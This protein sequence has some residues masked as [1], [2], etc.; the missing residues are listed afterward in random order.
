MTGRMISRGLDES[1]AISGDEAISCGTFLSDIE[2]WADRLPESAHVINLCVDR[3]LFMVAF[4]AAI[5]RGQ[6]NLL[7]T[8]HQSE[9]V[10][11]AL[12][13]YPDAY[14]LSD[15]D[16]SDSEV[17][18]IKITRD[19]EP[20]DVAG[21]NPEIPD[22]QLAAVVFTSGSTGTSKPIPKT[23]GTL[24]SGAL[25]N[26]G[27]LLADG[28]ARCNLIATVPPWH[29]YGLEWSIMLCL[30]SNTTTYSGGTF[31]PDDI[32]LALERTSG[33]RILIS[34]PLHLRAM[35]NSGV[36]F[37]A[38]ET[39]LCA[40]APLDVDFAQDV[41]RNF[42]ASVFEI[43]GCSEAGSMA[44]RWPTRDEYWRFLSEFHVE[45]GNAKVQ[46]SADHVPD[47][48]ELADT[49][50]FR[51]DGSFL[52]EGRNED[53]VKVAG[54]RASLGELNSRLLA[55]EGIED[56]VI[57]DPKA[58]GVDSVRLSALVVSPSRNISD[59]RQ[60]LAR[61]VDPVFLPRPI[62]MVDRLPRSETG[63]LRR[64]ELSRMIKMAAEKS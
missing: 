22:T 56:G 3:Y 4:F 55:I 45:R 21:D 59:I 19:P 5:R 29:M 52:L 13:S 47:V 43:Y 40:T 16:F 18:A 62:K 12:Q 46:I 6:C 33:K 35:L 36:D 48:I 2:V 25:M 30:V 41:E 32:R 39:V 23:W 57:Y 58:F 54:K 1:V 20:S 37:P 15:H 51:A 50:S 7:L 60:D 31:F 44:C 42:S 9:I 10:R 8:G 17:Q 63:K 26:A 53:M 28:K 64:R 34:T 38:V 24:R 61:S 27:Y 11:E 49:L 14:V